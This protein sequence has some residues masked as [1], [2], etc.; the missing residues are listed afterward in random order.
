MIHHKGDHTLVDDS[1][2]TTIWA[3][4]TEPVGLQQQQE[5]TRGWGGDVRV[6]LGGDKRE[7]GQ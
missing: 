5:K 7:S 3:E 1:T 4:Q 2:P 6:A